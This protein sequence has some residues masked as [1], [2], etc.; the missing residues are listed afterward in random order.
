MERQEDQIKT[1]TEPNLQAF[2]DTTQP[3]QHQSLQNKGEESPLKTFPEN[4]EDKNNHITPKDPVK[5]NKR[6]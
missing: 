1:Q 5:V 6:K 3:F 4:D 2:D